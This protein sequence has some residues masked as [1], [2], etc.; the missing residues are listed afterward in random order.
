[1]LPRKNDQIRVSVHYRKLNAEAVDDLFPLP[2]TDAI[3]DTVAG[4]ELYIFL[5]TFNGYNQVCITLED[6]VKTAFLTNWGVYAVVVMMFGFKTVPYTF[7]RAIMEIFD[8][9]T[10]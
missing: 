6:Q 10:P 5:D 7:Q 3:P 2:F 4:Y 9:F 8:E 1:M